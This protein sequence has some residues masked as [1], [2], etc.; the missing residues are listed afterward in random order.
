VDLLLML[1][2]NPVYTAPADL[3]FTAA[4]DKFVAEKRPDDA[5]QFARLAIHLSPYYDET[6]FRCHWHLPESHYL[7]SWGDLRAFDGTVAIQ[8]PLIAP[9]YGTRSALEVVAGLLR[10]PDASGYDLVRKHWQGQEKYA[11][12]NFEQTWRKALHGGVLPDSALPPRPAA[13]AGDLGAAMARPQTPTTPSSLE[14]VFRPDPHIWD[15]RWANNGW[16]QETPKPL[17][18]LTWDNVIL[19][20]APTAQKL[21]YETVYGDD[22]HRPQITV[23]RG[24]REIT[25]AVWISYGHPDDALTV[26]LGYGR[27]RSGRVGGMGEET[28]G[29]N[30]YTIRTSDAQYIAAD[31]TFGDNKG[32]TYELAC[33]QH[34]Q[35]MDLPRDASGPAAGENLNK[36]RDLVRVLNYDELAKDAE[37]HHKAPHLSLY[38]EY[39]YDSNGLHKWGMVIDQNACMGCNACITA[40]QSEN[41]TAIV[42]KDEVIMQREM[43][44]LRIDTYYTG[45]P[46]SPDMMFQPMLCQHCEKAPCEVVCPVAAT[47]HSDEGIN[48]MTYNRCVGTRYCSNNCPYKVRRFNFLQYNDNRIASLK[49]M[50]NPDVTVR[51]RGV[52]EKCTYCVQ[53]VNGTRIEL[54]KLEVELSEALKPTSGFT[55]E[56]QQ[57]IR[58]RYRSALS[59][60]QTACQQVCP[61]EAIVFGDLNAGK[62]FK[63]VGLP[64]TELPVHKLK[65]LPDDIE[66]GLLT[67]LNTQPRTTYLARFKN[68]NPALGAPTSGEAPKGPGHA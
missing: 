5:R 42:G 46:I 58:E 2:G 27:E 37:P 52:M 61:T 68:S 62:K 65:L 54:K 51:N 36:Q 39:D 14:I 33:T 7:E 43:H 34:H 28:H 15:G 25:G 19:M 20:S 35:V 41:N 23:R 66:Y 6:S 26:H 60:L 3:D 30:A 63:S 38:P 9:L 67:E 50:R 1:G 32:K 48:E 55:A 16:L 18:K 8:Q 4:L 59:T 45:D 49:L 24:N 17:T 22:R 29:F 53:R 12:D 44:W 47:T 56:E 31:V 40:C 13:L 21:G 57:R 64:Q 10:M 11:G